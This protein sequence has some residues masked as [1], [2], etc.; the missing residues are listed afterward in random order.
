MFGAELVEV[1]GRRSNASE[2]A[3]TAADEG[4]V[5]ASH[6]YMPQGLRGYSTIAYELVEQLGGAPGSVIMPA[7]HG[8]L[9]LGAGRG[10][11]SMVNSG[12]IN[13]LPMLIGVQVEACAPLWSVFTHG[14]MGLN[15][16]RE[17]ETIAEGIRVR[18]PVR[19]DAVLQMV[20]DSKGF[21]GQVTE[22]KVLSGVEALAQLG[23]SVEP[24][25][26]VIWGILEDH[27]DH[28]PEPIVV[29]LTGSG[30]KTG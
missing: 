15:W 27:I 3:R 17:D 30:L 12:E 24:T 1:V 21:I 9:L 16:V 22:D 26:A 14:P 5:Y 6:A 2:A 18:Y 8:G 23:Y 20:L 28:L 7:G 25:S 10:F 13:K 11:V 4:E 29:I 19:G